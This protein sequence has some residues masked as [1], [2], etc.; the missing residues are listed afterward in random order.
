ML[1]YFINLSCTRRINK[2]WVKKEQHDFPFS[3]LDPPHNASKIKI[4][5]LRK[6]NKK[7]IIWLTFSHLNLD[8]NILKVSDS[9]HYYFRLRITCGCS[10]TAWSWTRPS[11]PRQRRQWPS[12]LRISGPSAF[13]P[14]SFKLHCKRNIHLTIN[15]TK[16]LTI[17]RI[18]H[19]YPRK[20]LS[21][22]LSQENVF[23]G[24]VVKVHL[25][26]GLQSL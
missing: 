16:Y 1:S 10:W 14:T 12:G 24:F 23:K 3:F 21:S 11:T 7:N 18:K 22:K 6:S 13:S 4:K 17:S 9:E 15:F 26:L 5:K 19:L 25:I 20:W 2:F 8:S